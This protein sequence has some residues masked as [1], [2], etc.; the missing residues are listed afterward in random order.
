[1]SVSEESSVVEDDSTGIKSESVDASIVNLAEIGV[2][3][4]HAHG[5]ICRVDV[6]KRNPND[7]INN[8]IKK[9]IDI[10]NI[11]YNSRCYN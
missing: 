10:G 6:N 1:M 5:F 2:L 3:V 11:P 7:Y 4:A 8:S 9:I